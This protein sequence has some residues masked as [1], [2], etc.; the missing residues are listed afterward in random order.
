M[1]ANPVEILALFPSESDGYPSNSEW[2]AEG[3]VKSDQSPI[4]TNLILMKSSNWLTLLLWI[5]RLHFSLHMCTQAHRGTCNYKR[6]TKYCIQ[7]SGYLRAWLV[8]VICF[9]FL[10]QLTQILWYQKRT[11]NMWFLQHAIR[12]DNLQSSQ[13]LLGINCPLSKAECD[14]ESVLTS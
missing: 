4:L 2:L 13:R 10:N 8:Q 5:T 7:V 11:R 9:H 1:F 12:P 6:T 3:E 14:R